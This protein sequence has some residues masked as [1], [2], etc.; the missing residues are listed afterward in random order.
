LKAFEYLCLVRSTEISS[1]FSADLG[2][3]AKYVSNN[4]TLFGTAAGTFFCSVTRIK[5][6]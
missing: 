5:T 6:N 4:L 1:F 3:L 2:F